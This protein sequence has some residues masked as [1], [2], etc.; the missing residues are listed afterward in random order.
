MKVAEA[1]SSAATFD[2]PNA[3]RAK[4]LEKVPCDGH[5]DSSVFK[6][7]VASSNQAA[8]DSRKV[9]AASAGDRGWKQSSRGPLPLLTLLTPLMPLTLP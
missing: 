7:L 5:V 9:G 4:G 1:L 2:V 6:V 8:K 3:A